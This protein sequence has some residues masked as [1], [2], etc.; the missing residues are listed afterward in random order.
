VRTIKAPRAIL[1]CLLLLAILGSGCT[2]RR[3]TPDVG[4]L[5]VAPT[6]YPT[7]PASVG[8]GV[9]GI[10]EDIQ[11]LTVRVQDGQFVSDVYDMQLR[12]ARIEVWASHGPYTFQIDG[13]VNARPLDADGMTLIGLT[14][15]GPG[16]LTMRLSGSGTDTATLNV[17]VAGDR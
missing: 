5:P 16:R 8:P 11:A 3:A 7:G 10:S 9:A 2:D 17:R 6:A 14:P 12:P 4:A 15:A 13:L 1:G